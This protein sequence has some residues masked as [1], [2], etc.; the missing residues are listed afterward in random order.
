MYRYSVIESVK[1]TTLPSDENSNHDFL[2]KDLT[3][4]IKLMTQT[5]CLLL[6]HRLQALCAIDPNVISKEQTMN[7]LPFSLTLEDDEDDKKKKSD[8]KLKNP[9][10]ILAWSTAEIKERLN[11]LIGDNSELLHQGRSIEC[12]Y[13]RI[14][15]K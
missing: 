4:M 10:K 2:K 12:E 1:S 14:E 6:L 15:F 7:W 9:E 8:K 5:R 11:M 13:I 3:E